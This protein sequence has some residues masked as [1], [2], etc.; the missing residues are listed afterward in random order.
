[1]IFGFKSV[2]QAAA[3]PFN[4]EDGRLRVLVVSSRR[5][6]RWVIPKGWPRKHESLFDTAAREAAEEAGVGGVIG[7]DCIGRYGYEKRMRRGYPVACETFVFPLLVSHQDE[8]WPERKRRRRH[9]CDLADAVRLVDDADLARLLNRH[10]A[11]DGT[12]LRALTDRHGPTNRLTCT[13]QL[14]LL[15]FPTGTQHHE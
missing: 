15:H 1:M 6:G 13:Q 11:E 2:Q 10:L 8:D 4:D 9:W 3:L 14:N 5:R 7:Q 12:A